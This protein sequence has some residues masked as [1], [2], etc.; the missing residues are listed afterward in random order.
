MQAGGLPT[1]TDDFLRLA[2]LITRPQDGVY[3]IVDPLVG[4]GVVR[5]VTPWILSLFG[6]PNQWEVKNGK[7]IKDIEHEGYRA[8][9][10]FTRS[11]FAAGVVH[12][13]S[14]NVSSNGSLNTGKSAFYAGPPIESWMYSWLRAGG[15]IPFRLLLPFGYDGKIKPNHHFLRGSS[16]KVAIKKGSEERT[17]ELLAIANFIQSPFGTTEFHAFFYGV[18]GVDY[19]WKDG[20]PIRTA[21]GLKEVQMDACMS[22]VK[23]IYSFIQSEDVGKRIQ[24]YMKELL[25]IAIQDPTLGLYSETDQTEGALLGNLQKDAMWEIVNGRLPM[26]AFDQLVK[27]WRAKGGDKIR[28]EFEEELARKQ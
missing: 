23:P 3:A 11:L 27:D 21:Q 13:D 17:R 4:T 10:E 25:P 15:R 8:A 22:P 7:L 16:G 18:E 12:P 6:V 26:S 9:L 24:D 28:A 20:H 5:G 1:N 14:V 19:E 2:K